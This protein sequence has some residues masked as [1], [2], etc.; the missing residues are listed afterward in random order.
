V[1]RIRDQARA[2]EVMSER[3]RIV[4]ELDQPAV[5]EL[6]VGSYRLIYEISEED[7]YVLG[8]IHGARDL[9]AL[10]DTESRGGPGDS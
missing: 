6:V 10:W 7:V 1:R 9:T 8:L 2:L 3:G 4:P 5:R